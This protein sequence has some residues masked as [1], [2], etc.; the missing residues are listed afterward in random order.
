MKSRAQWAEKKRFEPHGYIY[1]N[2]RRSSSEDRLPHIRY[3]EMILI[4][5]FIALQAV[6]DFHTVTGSQQVGAGFEQGQC[7]LQA[8][9]FP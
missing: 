6:K 5:A 8:V 3:W 4:P 9:D 7:F 2:S 1:E